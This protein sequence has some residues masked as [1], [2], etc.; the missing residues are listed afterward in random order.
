MIAKVVSQFS[1]A[2]L[3]RL[4]G[5]QPLSKKLKKRKLEARELEGR[6]GQNV[7]KLLEEK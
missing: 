2:C 7:V 6:I 5:G 3:I 4:P 1:E